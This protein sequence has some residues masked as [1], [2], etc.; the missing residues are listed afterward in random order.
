[1]PLE[2]VVCNKTSRSHVFVIG[3][4]GALARDA[5]PLSAAK[6]HMA[7]WFARINAPGGRPPPTALHHIHT[8]AEA[9]R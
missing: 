7:P 3:V 5:S 9:Y 2:H 8:Q 4:S 1:M 6:H